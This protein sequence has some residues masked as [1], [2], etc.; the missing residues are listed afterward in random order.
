MLKGDRRSTFG[1]LPLHA[2]FRYY[3]DPFRLGPRVK[4]DDDLCCTIEWFETQGRNPSREALDEA[5][6]KRNSGVYPID[7]CVRVQVTL[8]DAPNSHKE[9]G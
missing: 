3:P 5:S 8:A 7:G 9:I 4:V 1:A 2:V 6:W